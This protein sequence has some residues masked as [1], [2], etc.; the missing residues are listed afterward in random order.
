MR[1]LEEADGI[2][3]APPL[4]Y[5]EF[6]GLMSSARIVLTDSGGLREETT[7]LGIPCLTLR[8]NTERPITITEGTNRLVGAE[9][10]AIREAFNQAMESTRE[11]GR[12]P[13]LWDGETAGRITAILEAM[14]GA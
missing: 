9:P 8:P 7:A 12:C 2:R 1:L 11:S 6:Q 5:L 14:C 4:G 3:L 13:D 10:G